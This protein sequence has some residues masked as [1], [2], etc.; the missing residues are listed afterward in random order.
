MRTSYDLLR[1]AASLSDRFFSLLWHFSTC[2][3]AYRS[4]LGSCYV[5]SIV[6]IFRF[7]GILQSLYSGK[8][9]VQSLLDDLAQLEPEDDGLVP[10]KKERPQDK[11]I[12]A[13]Q[14]RL[15][16]RLEVVLVNTQ[17]CEEEVLQIV[18]ADEVNMTKIASRIYYK[19]YYSASQSHG[20]LHMEVCERA[21]SHLHGTHR[22]VRSLL[23]RCDFDVT[24]DT[25]YLYFDR[26]SRALKGESH[27]SH[28]VEKGRYWQSV[29]FQG[30]DP[31]TDFRGV[32]EL[33]LQHLVDFCERHPLYSARM[34]IESGTFYAEGD[35]RLGGPWYPFALCGIHISSFITTL[36]KQSLLQRH[37]IQAEL[38]GPD[39][40]ELFSNALYSFLFV[41]CHLDWAEGVDKKEITT[42]FQFE[43]FFREFEDHTRSSLSRLSWDN[44]DLYPCRRWW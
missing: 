25:H 42:V 11:A 5:W 15:L 24:W 35:K 22:C 19:V 18:A 8:T 9:P 41:R 31:S 23:A 33:G 38:R 39:G 27:S 12:L 1:P 34:I 17:S 14:S 21:L 40:I 32:G 36:L 10:V 20:Q 29:G 3:F 44:D 30:D 2:P 43:Q 4:F 26:L 7:I 6:R 28:K 16:F 37:L 13:A